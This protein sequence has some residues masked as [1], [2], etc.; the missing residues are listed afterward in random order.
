MKILF[1]KIYKFTSMYII[2]NAIKQ[3]ALYVY[4]HQ[5]LV[6]NSLWDVGTHRDNHVN[7]DKCLFRTGI[8]DERGACLNKTTGDSFRSG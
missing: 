4:V 3:N 7:Y 2:F 8:S 6:S 1:H 5:L